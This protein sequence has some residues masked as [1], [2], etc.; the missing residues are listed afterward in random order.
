M[1]NYVPYLSTH[2]SKMV[3]VFFILMFQLWG[4]VVALPVFCV[5][6]RRYRI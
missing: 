4:V 5:G 2:G 3:L 6:Y 1:D